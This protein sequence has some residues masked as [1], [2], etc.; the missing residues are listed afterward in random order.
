[1][2]AVNVLRVHRLGTDIPPFH[3]VCYNISTTFYVSMFSIS[4][5]YCILSLRT[6]QD[7]KQKT[8][9]ERI[10]IRDMSGGNVDAGHK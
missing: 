9:T 2:L 3:D 5:R 7:T 6:T 4:E 10:I 1:M 8:A